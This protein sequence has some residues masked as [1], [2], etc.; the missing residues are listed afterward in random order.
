[1]MK[2][3]IPSHA[4]RAIS[5]SGLII[6]LGIVYGDIGTSPLYVMKAILAG[7]GGSVDQSLVLGA[8]SCIIWTLTLQTTLKYVVIS[9]RAD[10]R[11][12]GGILALY[13][14]VRRQ[15][16]WL[17][18]FAI[19][20]A[21][22]LLADGVITPA[23]T[24]MS[25]VEGLQFQYPSI[26]VIPIALTIV[27]ALFL[28][29]QFGTATIGKSFGP[30][31]LIWFGMI[32]ILGLVQ[33]VQLPLVLKAFNP[34]Y[35]VQLLAQYPGGFLLLGAV[36]L[37]TTGAEA[38]YSDLGHCGAN[39][40]RISW[41]FV[42]LSLILNYLGQ[43][44]W[45][46]NQPTGMTDW[47]NPFFAIM[48][49]WFLP[50]GV[51]VATAAAIIASQALISGSYTIVSEA[52]QLKLWP[53]VRIS[54]PTNRKGQMYISSVNW[55]LFIFV[56]TVILIFQGSS[57]VEAAYGLAITLTML[58]TT[59]LMTF[60]LIRIKR[61]SA[62]ILGFLMIYLTIEGAFLIANLAKFSHGGWF[63]L[64][65]AGII[66]LVMYVW[67]RGRTLKN[68]FTRFV[69]ISDYYDAIRDLSEDTS[70]PKYA[71]NLVYL[72][73]A[74]RI[75]DTEAKIIFSIFNKKPKRADTYWLLHVHTTDE[76]Y[77]A[78][79]SVDYL[80]PGKL[81]RVEFRLGFKVQ[82]RI[83]LYFKQMLKELEAAGEIKL[84]SSYDSLKKHRIPADFHFIIIR[85][86]QNY[87]FDFPPVD[88]FIM[89]IYTLLGRLSTS[90]I[91]AYGLDTSNVV[92][93]KVPFVLETDKKQEMKR[94]R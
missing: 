34:V 66:A 4:R 13:A 20:G 29:Q 23:I 62:F 12:E 45:I 72:T 11:G 43:G 42:K 49:N 85:R 58:M 17:F 76:P 30:V 37:C 74:D 79:Y 40:I 6:T 93:E 24:I 19:I 14:L 25:S 69:R 91:R 81:I 94:L 36:F 15:R 10:N 88:Q 27:T 78:S 68:R 77:S 21:S 64:M 38:L 63:T 75:T 2:Q 70:V 22:T 67:Y 90:D 92:E 52:I 61:N 9:L 48:P 55:L 26:N 82:P 35:A 54:Y 41:I 1:M 8:I 56:V 5:L 3:H 53:K 18:I 47:P 31:M 65:L 71:S 87:D 33:V 39:N 16:K 84:D 73:H 89:D 7:S 32:A 60:Y 59:L 83:N 28:I 86:I 50:I 80:I 44:A 46:L 57:R 51:I